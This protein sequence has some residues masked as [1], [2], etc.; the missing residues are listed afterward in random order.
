MIDAQRC[1]AAVC[2]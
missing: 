2:R 1:A